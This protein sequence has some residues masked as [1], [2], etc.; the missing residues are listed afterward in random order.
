M[1]RILICFSF[2]FVVILSVNAQ[3]D[4]T[5]AWDKDEKEMFLGLTPFV[6]PHVM[7]IGGT[8]KGFFYDTKRSLI[9]EEP[10]KVSRG[11]YSIRF[12]IPSEYTDDRNFFTF[13]F[14]RNEATSALIESVKIE[15]GDSVVSTTAFAEIMYV[16]M[17][18]FLI[19]R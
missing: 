4:T 8:I 10:K 17:T 13:S 1:K 11:R 14:V 16:L 9:A 6:R 2:F 12:I 15:A 7:D 18:F 19:E 3:A 5:V